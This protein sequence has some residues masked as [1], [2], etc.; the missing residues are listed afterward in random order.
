MEGEALSLVKMEMTA[1]TSPSSP[2]PPNP[3][4]GHPLVL[5]FSAR[6]CCTSRSCSLTT[7]FCSHNLPSNFWGPEGVGG[8]KGERRG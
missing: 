2:P 8:R 6:S 1:H 5:T 3:T 7:L 4:Q